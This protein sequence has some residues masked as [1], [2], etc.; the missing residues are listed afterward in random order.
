MTRCEFVISGKS[1][2][3]QKSVLNSEL[4]K[5]IK[6]YKKPMCLDFVVEVCFVV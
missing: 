3:W 4:Q 2:I 6:K 1:S 5:Y